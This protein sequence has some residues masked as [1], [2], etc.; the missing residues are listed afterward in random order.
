MANPRIEV[1]IGA[2]INEFEKKFEKVDDQVN[3]TGKE[4]TK[5]NEFAVGALQGIAAAFTVG[6]IV[7]FGKAVLDTTAKFQKFE[8]VLRTTLGSD[9][10]AT[11]ALQNIKEF[12]TTTPFGV[13]EVTGAFIKLANQGFKPTVSEL[14]SLGDLAASTGKSFD[15]LAESII[16]AQV[17]EFERL[18]EFGVRAK[19]SG[20]QVTF[21]FKGVETQ[22]KNT[23][24]AIQGYVLGLGEAEG[25]TGSMAGISQTL[26]GKISELGDNIEQVRLAIGNQ[27]S[28]IT[29]ATIEWLNGFAK[30][31]QRVIKGTKELINEVRGFQ[32]SSE[33]S[34]TK[35]EIDFLVQ[36][37]Q[38][39]NPALT[40]QEAIKKAVDAV[41]E[42]Y[43]KLSSTQLQNGNI[44]IGQLQKTLRL[45]EAYG[46]ELIKSSNKT[47]ESGQT[48]EQFSKTWDDYNRGLQTTAILNDSLAKSFDSLDEK[49]AKLSESLVPVVNS[50]KEFDIKF[51]FE[52]DTPQQD[53]IPEI[54]ESK[55]TAFVL[56][57]QEFNNQVAG[58]LEGTIE[59]T[60]GNFAFAIGDALARGGDVLKA[61]GAVLL[62]GLA[63]ILNQLGQM[64]IE[65]GITIGAIK[66]ALKTLNP[67]IAIGAGVALIALA[68]FVSAKARSLAGVGGGGTSAV[69]TS[70][71]GSGTSFTGGGLGFAF[72]P[73]REIRGELVAR[74]SDLVYVFNEAN[75]RINKG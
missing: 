73:N 45:I 17:G 61:G 5:L 69:G 20:D 52:G 53:I 62:E 3:K 18:K 24:Q 29:K 72:D 1:E 68:G 67:A 21:T 2:K 8:A 74:G 49:I 19:V 50:F 63:G 56:R 33:I 11:E 37:F 31:L 40:K 51:N 60:L 30:D 46:N 54:D 4:F 10:A 16:D 7:N 38:K 35:K 23:S 48:F 42:S 65:T 43:K 75:N 14:R 32:F 64:A 28:G 34:E 13:D 36:S 27:T 44:S 25:V 57:L 47:E 66:A 39:I 55:L 15:Q 58:V 6:S 12:A 22:V 70:G 71:V 9:S 59:Q 26:G 41:S